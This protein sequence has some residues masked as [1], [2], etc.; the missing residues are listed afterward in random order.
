MVKP[1]SYPIPDS[2]DSLL[3]REPTA[4]AL[5][6][7]GYPIRAKTLA[8]KAT[9]GGGPPFR[10]FGPWPLYRWGDALAWAQSRLEEPRYTTSEA[11]PP[12]GALPI[13]A[14]TVVRIDETAR[15]AEQQAA[16]VGPDQLAEAKA[17]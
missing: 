12:R 5:T 11:T 15:E 14:R 8:T 1:M 10:K 7:L 4:E 16:G 2:P 17:P 3:R 13:E 9:R 6:A